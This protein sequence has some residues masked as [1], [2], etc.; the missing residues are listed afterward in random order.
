MEEL[1]MRDLVYKDKNGKIVDNPDDYFASLEEDVSI[2]EK[3]EVGD[4]VKLKNFAD[5]IEI[6]YTD[7]EI[8]NV[9]LVDY[10]GKNLEHD[11]ENLTLFN[12]KDIE[13]FEKA[14]SHGK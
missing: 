10:A 12:Q 14:R 5:K 1:N 4:I 6:L 3:L 11:T 13:T 2:E 7:Y 8:P 9:G